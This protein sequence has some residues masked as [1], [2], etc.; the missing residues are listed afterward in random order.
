MLSTTL[1]L[2]IQEDHRIVDGHILQRFIRGI[3]C[4]IDNRAYRIED[5]AIAIG[6]PA[7]CITTVADDTTGSP[8]TNRP[9]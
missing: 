5:V 6:S 9:S 1:V 3:Y 4:A 8:H 2:G 7:S